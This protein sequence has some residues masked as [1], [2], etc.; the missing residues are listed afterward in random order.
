MAGQL[1]RRVFSDQQISESKGRMNA[2]ER[3]LEND[4]EVLLSYLIFHRCR[5]S[6][7]GE[8]PHQQKRNGKWFY[9]SLLVKLA[10]SLE[11]AIIRLTSQYFFSSIA[12][13][14]VENRWEIYTPPQIKVGKWSVL[15]FVQLHPWFGGDGGSLFHFIL[16]KIAASSTEDVSPWL[17]DRFFTGVELDPALVM[18]MPCIN[19]VWCVTGDIKSFK[20]CFQC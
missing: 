17:S 15:P 20:I 6:N 18:W 16:S 5:R 7:I 9:H 11:I 2:N 14:R 13:P 12:R 10:N 8:K 19:D 1:L 3:L 4:T